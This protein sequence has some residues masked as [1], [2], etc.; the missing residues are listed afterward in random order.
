M[1][2][3]EIQEKIDFLKS[4][5]NDPTMPPDQAEELKPALAKLEAKLAAEME[6]ASSAAI[7]PMVDAPAPDAVVAKP[8]KE[9][10]PKV[11]VSPDAF[12]LKI[13]GII[14]NIPHADRE[15]ALKD[16]KIYKKFLTA[17]VIEKVK[18]FCNE[19]GVWL[20]AND[21]ERPTRVVGAIKEPKASVKKADKTDTSVI[22]KVEEAAILLKDAAAVTH[23][24]AITEASKATDKAK[25]ELT[26]TNPKTGSKQSI[27]KDAL[28]SSERAVTAAAM[29]VDHAEDYIVGKHD[30]KGFDLRVQKKTGNVYLVYKQVGAT[31]PALLQLKYF[32]RIDFE[33]KKLVR[34]KDEV[35]NTTLLGF[36]ASDRKLIDDLF[37]SLYSSRGFNSGSGPVKKGLRLMK[38]ILEAAFRAKGEWSDEQE[39]YFEKQYNMY[40]EEL[41]VYTPQKEQRKFLH[42][43]I[44]VHRSGNEKYSD[45]KKRILAEQKSLLKNK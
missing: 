36:D 43:Y 45:A 18:G 37:E 31:I 28:M 35:S 15:K 17:G 26:L 41:S 4:Q 7:T 3:T 38:E 29:I 11:E 34:T 27:T 40:D 20:L 1:S 10:K 16:A 22:E 25:Q 24:K 39:K 44:A 32:Y 13:V 42:D 21:Y 5:I 2:T 19:C 8:K 6:A 9:K 33:Q 12:P 30:E 14:Q 23:N